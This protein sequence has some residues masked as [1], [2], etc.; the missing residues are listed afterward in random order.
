MTHRMLSVFAV[1][2]AAA[3]FVPSTVVAQQPAPAPAAKPAPKPAPKPAQ[4]Q[5]RPVAPAQQAPAP[6]AQA[7]PQDAPQLIF[8]PWAKFCNKPQ[9]ASVKSVCFTGRDARTEA[10]APVLGTALIEPEGEPKKIFRVTLPS[11]IQLLYG[12]RIVI[13]TNEPATAPFFTCLPNGLCMADYEATP[14]LIGKLKKGTTLAVKF[15]NV[16]GNEVSFPVA[17]ADFAKANEG[18]PTDPKVL[19]EQTKKLQEELQKR[20]DEARKKLEAQQPK[21]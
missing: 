10:G 17:L 8:S 7:Q 18:P 9:D 13:D 2:T 19:E 1:A 4:A 3:F 15:M 11:P 20:A 6:Q 14:D 16:G 21:Q 5:P 12:A